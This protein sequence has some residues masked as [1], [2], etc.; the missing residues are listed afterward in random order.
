MAGDKNDGLHNRVGPIFRTGEL[1]GVAIQALEEDNPGRTFHV[2]DRAA[3]VRVATDHE[4]IIRRETME[5]ILGRPFE[6]QEL[7]TVLGS[8]SGQIESTQ[9][10]I[11]FYFQKTL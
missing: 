8:F 4:C 6:M 7:E 2:D 5:A 1:A 3:Y 11:R 10:Y 9:E